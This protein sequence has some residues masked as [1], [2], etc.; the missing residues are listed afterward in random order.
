MKVRIK[1]SPEEREVDGLTL[2]K[3]DFEPGSIRDVSSVLGSW[4][5]VEGYAEPEMRRTERP[6]SRSESL[7]E[8]RRKSYAHDGNR[9]T[10][11][12]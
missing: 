4:L 9:R 1:T 2:S 5:I 10:N 11:R 8:E 12:S 3:L 7:L 6:R